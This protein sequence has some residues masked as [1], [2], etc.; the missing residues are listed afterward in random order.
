[1]FF[2]IVF[3]GGGMSCVMIVLV[4]SLLG[5]LGGGI[6]VLGFGVFGIFDLG[7]FVDFF[8]IL[9]CGVGVIWLEDIVLFFFFELFFDFVVYVLKLI[10]YGVNILLGIVILGIFGLCI[11]CLFIFSVIFGIF[12][13]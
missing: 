6:D 8:M 1:M 7:G 3:L 2:G 13:I 4:D 5:I 12:D 9:M 11:F 10:L